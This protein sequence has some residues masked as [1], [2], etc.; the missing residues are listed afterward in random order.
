M[1]LR[2]VVAFA[3]AFAFVAPRARAQDADLWRSFA[4]KLR[5][6]ALVIV[7]VSD[8][9]TVKGQLVQVTP[10]TITVLPKKRLAVPV[11]ALPFA[12][13]Q[14]IEKGR[15]GMSPGAKVLIGGGSAGAFLVIL[16]ALFAGG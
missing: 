14:S 1:S 13:I 15:E 16:A 11:R 4:E 6:G 8:G 12:A 10:D 7:H 5:P 2:S 3:L 9:S